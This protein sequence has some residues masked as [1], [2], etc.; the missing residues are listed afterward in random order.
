MKLRNLFLVLT[1]AFGLCACGTTAKTSSETPVSN[2][3]PQTDPL[4]IELDSFESHTF[5]NERAYIVICDNTVKGQIPSV[6]GMV[7]SRISAFSS[8]YALQFDNCSAKVYEPKFNKKGTQYSFT[9]KVE[10]AKFFGSFRDTDWR[11]TFTIDGSG[12]VSMMIESATIS[13]VRNTAIWSFRG[14]VNPERTEALKML[15][16]QQ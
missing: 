9:V 12:F 10:D 16:G 13:S 6:N 2:I 4:V 8:R 11:M 1:A 5:G 7:T 15:K 3:V 14:H